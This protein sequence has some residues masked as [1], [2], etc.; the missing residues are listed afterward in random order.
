MKKIALD[1]YLDSH[2]IH[3]SKWL[4]A[5]VLGTKNGIISALSLAPG[6]VAASSTRDPGVYATVAGLVARAL[7][8]AAGE[9]V[10]V[11]SPTDNCVGKVGRPQKR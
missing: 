11:S 7:S 8:M 1:N 5:G 2:Y 6:V 4:R 3:R 9:Y 10:S